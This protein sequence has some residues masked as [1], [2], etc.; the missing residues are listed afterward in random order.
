MVACRQH[1]SQMLDGL[2][3]MTQQ[4]ASAS[5]PQC[6]ASLLRLTRAFADQHASLL[7]QAVPPH[8][9]NLLAEAV[10][11]SVS[12]C[13]SCVSHQVQAINLRLATSDL[14]NEQAGTTSGRNCF[15]SPYTSFLTSFG[16]LTEQKQC[17]QQILKTLAVIFFGNCSS[18]ALSPVKF[19]PSS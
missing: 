2:A 13:V 14:F 19:L 12:L 18:C 4:A 7:P 16:H 8:F 5:A 17:V 9:V 3:L 15:L 11:Q 1:L 6:A 10:K